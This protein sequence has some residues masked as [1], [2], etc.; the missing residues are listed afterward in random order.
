M[1]MSEKKTLVDEGKPTD[2][3]GTAEN[4]PSKVDSKK[5][6]SEIENMISG[7]QEEP[8]TETDSRVEI[9]PPVKKKRRGRRKK[10]AIVEGELLSGAMFL[11]LV[12]TI[13][14]TLIC[15]V[16]NQLSKKKVTPDR[17]MLSPNQKKE[18]E[19]L[20]AQVA[21]QLQAKGDPVSLFIL[22]MLSLYGINLMMVR[23]S[24]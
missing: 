21:E 24:M 7:Y 14:P 12:D 10:T 20:A 1:I 15:A 13:F 22:T 2:T 11:F 18:L 5:N 3:N 4:E 16:H 17:L 19:P 9:I 23:Q 8:N 6:L